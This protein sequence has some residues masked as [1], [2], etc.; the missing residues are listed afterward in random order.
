MSWAEAWVCR[1]AEFLGTEVAPAVGDNTSAAVD[2]A[3]VAAVDI[4]CC[5]TSQSYSAGA[6][7]R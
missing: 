3:A 7:R 6:D 4:C 5:C 1:P 2:A